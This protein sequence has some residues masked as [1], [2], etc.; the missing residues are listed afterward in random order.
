MM[1]KVKK[2]IIFL[3]KSSNYERIRILKIGLLYLKSFFFVTYLP[4]K[5]YF[6]NYCFGPFLEKDELQPYNFEI[7]LI[8]R[9]GKHF[10]LK[11]TCL[12]E[13]MV[14]QDYLRQYNLIAPISLGINKFEDVKAHAWIMPLNNNGFKSIFK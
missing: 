11:I 1:R 13:S 10:P 4:L 5:N 2:L 14:I 8:K 9:L 6:S 3:N 7:S 12:M